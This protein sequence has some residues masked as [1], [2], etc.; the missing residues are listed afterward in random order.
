M[1]LYNLLGHVLFEHVA[2]SR[3][4]DFWEFHLSNP[5]LFKE[6]RHFALQLK[7]AGRRKCSARFIFERIRWER[8]IYTTDEEF[9]INNNFI[10]LYGRLLVVKDP[11]M[12]G[13]FFE[14]RVRKARLNDGYDDYDPNAE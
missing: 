10:P 9:K 12:F 13:N 1:K 8:A 3:V 5:D 11:T 7:R 14:F 4:H 6:F 2:D